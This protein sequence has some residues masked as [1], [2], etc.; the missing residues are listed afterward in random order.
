MDPLTRQPLISPATRSASS[1]LALAGTILS[2]AVLASA[3]VWL[4]VPEA[5]PYAAG[6]SPVELLLGP[7]ETASV[8]AAAVQAVAGAV[9]AAVGV[10]IVAG[11]AAQG[12]ALPAVAVLLTA[13]AV[14][15][16]LVG[17]D[18]IVIA[19][20]SLAFLMPLGTA[21]M[22]VALVVRRPVVGAAVTAGVLGLVAL[23]VLAS[24]PLAE[25][26]T[27]YAAA[28]ADDPVRFVTAIGL[29]AFV[30]AWIP[31]SAVRL[32]G[33]FQRA[34]AFAERHRI[35]LTVSAAACAL[36]YVVAR[37]TWLT[38]WPLFGG[39]AESFSAHP[40][41]LVVGLLLGAAMLLGAVLTLG[42]V[43]PWGTRIPRWIPVVGGEPVPMPLAVVPA[44]AAAV[45][46][47]AGGIQ[48]LALVAAGTLPLDAV[49]VLPFWLWGPLLALST[50]GYVRHRQAFAR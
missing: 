41:M 8:V 40:D 18:G 39:S 43:L 9:T 24:L 3:L 45:L 22:L 19:G 47:T 27:R 7:G 42:L 20:Y 25:F 4:V 50:W 12:S 46:F 14:A 23:S 17:F 36:P 33:R 5:G 6:R 37:A 48:S 21:G 49:L 35:A 32:A 15:I 16:G 31:W 11:R 44:S 30:G 1:R 2:T 29:T 13:G 28:V 10:G 34:G 26:F 38:P